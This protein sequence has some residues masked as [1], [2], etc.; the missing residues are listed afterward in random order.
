MGYSN[1][2]LVSYTKISPN[3]TKNR[4]HKIDSV[5]IHCMVAQWTAKQCC[6]FFANPATGASSNYTV[7]YDGSIGQSVDEADRAWTSGGKDKNGNPIR[8]NGISGA[9]FDH[10][11]ITIEVASDT[12]H[13][14]A[15]TDKAYAALL[16]L[17]TDICKRNNNIKRLLWEG[18]KK[19]VGEL[20]VQNMGAHRWFAYKACPGDYL[21]NRFGRIA[22]AVNKRLGASESVPVPPT[23]EKKL[24]RVRKSWS[25]VKSQIGAY[26]ELENAKKQVDSHP[27]YKVFD[28]T[29]KMVYAGKA[30]TTFKP[31]L[32][33]VTTSELNIRK[34]AG[35]NYGTNG[36]IRNRGVYTIV[37]EKEG[38]GAKM[39]GK[40]KS[41]AGWISLDYTKKV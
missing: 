10:R 4:N 29:G 5:I 11:A 12:K 32:V 21:Y 41:G 38:Q 3:R 34:G 17:L 35:T 19:Y 1:S 14:Y 9:D 7:G 30:D 40:L 20:T 22:E 28:S 15:V 31:Y 36:A 26:T 18:D 37:A 8:V 23:A 13:P 6:D 27:G 39:W 2:P 33:R 16:D 25:D 24:Y